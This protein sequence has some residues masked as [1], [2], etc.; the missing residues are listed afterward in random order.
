MGT[1]P[2]VSTDGL[3]FAVC[4]RVS[5]CLS[6]KKQTLWIFHWFLFHFLITNIFLS[7]LHFNLY[8]FIVYFNKVVVYQ[9]HADTLHFLFRTQATVLV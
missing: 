9:R 8:Y 3:F 6:E 7:S 4:F 2:V 5:F 1:L